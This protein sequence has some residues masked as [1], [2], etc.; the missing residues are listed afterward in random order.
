MRLAI[1]LLIR[2]LVIVFISYYPIQAQIISKQELNCLHQKALS[3]LSRHNVDVT[4]TSP[5]YHEPDPLYSFPIKRYFILDTVK[6][7]DA[8]FYRHLKD[9]SLEIDINPTVYIGKRIIRLNY[10][11]KDSSQALRRIT[12]HVLFHNTNYVGA[13][14][15]LDGYMGGLSPLNDRFHFKPR[16]IN[17]PFIDP[18]LL[19]TVAIVGPWD[20]DGDCC[21]MYRVNLL[22]QS[23]LT[24][25][26]EIL[27]NGKKKNGEL[28]YTKKDR[29]DKYGFVIR[30]KTGEQ[31]FPHFMIK[32]DS[33]F[34]DLAFLQFIDM[35]KE[36][37]Y[38]YLLDR[39]YIAFIKN[40][41]K[42]SGINNCC[43]K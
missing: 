35:K 34:L 42:T 31:I 21:W 13:Y 43:K 26:T 8:R 3:L 24:Y 27:A 2:V 18:E 38:H 12:A 11:L 20:K 10:I 22:S 15:I 33:L 41:I 30:F 7:Y 6:T 16:N 4:N 25:F 14:I 5:I 32:N 28:S 39:N 23:D 36:S 29:V 1:I 40:K 37:E 17:F 19:D 9:A